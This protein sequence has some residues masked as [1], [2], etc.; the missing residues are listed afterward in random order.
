MNEDRDTKSPML[1]RQEQNSPGLWPKPK[2]SKGFYAFTHSGE[3]L[4]YHCFNANRSLLSKT[5]TRE[6]DVHCKVHE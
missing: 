3:A 4:F 2:S 1:S 5:Y 6:I